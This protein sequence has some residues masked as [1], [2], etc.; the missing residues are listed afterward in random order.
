MAWPPGVVSKKMV[1]RL[2]FLALIHFGKQ[3][4]NESKGVK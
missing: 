1:K 3:M 2:S 4:S